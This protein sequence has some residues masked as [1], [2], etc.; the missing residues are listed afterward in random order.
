MTPPDQTVAAIEQFLAA[1]IEVRV[2]S[3]A[4]SEVVQP[5]PTC[6]CSGTERCTHVWRAPK[7]IEH[8][9]PACGDQHLS[10]WLR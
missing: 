3:N 9:C 2:A 1:P 5:K 10:P 6:I 4:P 7:R 8:E